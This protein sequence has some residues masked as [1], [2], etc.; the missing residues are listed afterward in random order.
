MEYAAKG[1]HRE[2]VDFFISKGAND[3]NWAMAYATKGGH[4]ELVDLFISKGAND[5]DWVW[6]T[7]RKEDIGSSLTSLFRREKMI[8]TR[9]CGSAAF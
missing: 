2:L 1:G 7:L 4:Q 8:G 5:W 3:W 9:L 6:L